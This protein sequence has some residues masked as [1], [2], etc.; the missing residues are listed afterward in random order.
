[1][2]YFIPTRNLS[3]SLD[4]VNPL[5][6]TIYTIYNICKYTQTE[7]APLAYKSHGELMDQERSPWLLSHPCLAYSIVENREVDVRS[8]SKVSRNI[9]KSERSVNVHTYP[10]IFRK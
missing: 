5:I 8:D 4:R 9:I 3:Q 10:A 7:Q 6:Y 1:M 2:Y